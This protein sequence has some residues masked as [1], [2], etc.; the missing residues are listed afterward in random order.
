MNKYPLLR[1][2]YKQ[3]CMMEQNASILDDLSIIVSDE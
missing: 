1:T 3:Q 2:R